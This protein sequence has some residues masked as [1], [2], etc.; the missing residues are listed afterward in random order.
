MKGSEETNALQFKMLKAI[1]KVVFN[2]RR[3]ERSI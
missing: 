2:D 3:V 1:N